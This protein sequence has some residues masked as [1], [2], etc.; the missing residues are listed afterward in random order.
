[1]SVEDVAE[2]KK[3]VIRRIEKTEDET[4]LKR[5]TEILKSQAERPSI[6]EIYDE[7]KQQYGN[8]LQKLAQ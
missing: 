5:I 1:M 6:N 2:L 4:L 8:T 3:E 7:L